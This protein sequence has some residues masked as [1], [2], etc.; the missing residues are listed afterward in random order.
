[1]NMKVFVCALAVASAARDQ[2]ESH[3]NAEEKKISG[4][5]LKDVIGD[6]QGL[7]GETFGKESQCYVDFTIV[8]D[9]VLKNGEGNGKDAAT[10]FCN[11][12]SRNENGWFVVQT[13]LVGDGGDVKY[14]CWPGTCKLE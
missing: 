11:A 9:D 6:V 5:N 8:T 12:D 7:V 13:I 10:A 1:M 2:D 4:L 14:M 3:A